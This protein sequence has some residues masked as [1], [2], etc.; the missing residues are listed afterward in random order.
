MQSRRGFLAACGALALA[1]LALFTKP[2]AAAPRMTDWDRDVQAALV[3]MQRAM[4]RYVEQVRQLRG[5]MTSVY[6]DLSVLDS[7]R[8]LEHTTAAYNERIRKLRRGLKKRTG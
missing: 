1:P 4:E 7:L 2:A 3:Q 6:Y 8:R 5:D